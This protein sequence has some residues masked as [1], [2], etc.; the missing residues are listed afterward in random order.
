MRVVV[1]VPVVVAEIPEFEFLARGNVAEVLRVE[2][3]DV[4]ASRID[5]FSIEDVNRVAVGEVS[6]AILDLIDEVGT[7]SRGMKFTGHGSA[8][9]GRD[10]VVVGVSGSTVAIASNVLGAELCSQTGI[11]RDVDRT[12]LRLPGSVPDFHHDVGVVG[13]RQVRDGD[14]QIKVVLGV[15]SGG[16]A[17]IGAGQSGSGRGGVLVIIVVTGAS[18]AWRRFGN[19]DGIGGIRVRHIRI[20][21]EGRRSL[22]SIGIR[23]GN[24]IPDPVGILGELH[25]PVR[26]GFE[27][28][29]H[30]REILVE[31]EL[32]PG[33]VGHHLE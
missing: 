15:S 20:G 22:G 5:R 2:L 6:P 3:E 7:T 8:Q 18:A 1:A 9:A 21:R 10:R 29:S 26:P 14:G 19:F 33:L 12:G 11:H 32:D 17:E 16:L 25:R 24:V 28:R 30:F 31:D 13:R 27:V 4:G 23:S